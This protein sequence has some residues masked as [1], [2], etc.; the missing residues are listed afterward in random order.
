LTPT[1]KCMLSTPFSLTI[2]KF[3]TTNSTI[4]P[5]KGALAM[6]FVFTKHAI[7]TRPS[8]H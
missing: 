8:C 7:L 3:S 2:D 6:L 1:T 4:G 5:G